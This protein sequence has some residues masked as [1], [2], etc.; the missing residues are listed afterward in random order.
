MAP[1]IHYIL[2]KELLIVQT[3]WFSTNLAHRAIKREW[4]DL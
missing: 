2:A 3:G 4:L 1:A